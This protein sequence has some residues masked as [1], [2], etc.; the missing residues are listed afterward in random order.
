MTNRKRSHSRKGILIAV[1]LGPLC[2]AAADLPGRAVATPAE[3]VANLPMQAL[4]QGKLA[5]GGAATISN[6][7][8]LRQQR[9][10]ERSPVAVVDSPASACVVAHSGLRLAEDSNLVAAPY[11][12]KNPTSAGP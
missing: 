3:P 10:S 4:Q 2:A 11:W 8:S 6:R 7:S 12:L 9:P 1:V 5:S